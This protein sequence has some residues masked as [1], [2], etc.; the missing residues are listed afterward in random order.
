MKQGG[1][2]NKTVRQHIVEQQGGYCLDAARVEEQ[3]RSVTVTLSPQLSETDVV[4]NRNRIHSYEAMSEVTVP[5]TYCLRC[6]EWRFSNLKSLQ[7][8]L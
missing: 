3:L 2:V 1:G 6:M 4:A 7:S 8:Y 5:V